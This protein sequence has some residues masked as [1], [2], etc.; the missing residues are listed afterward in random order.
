VV[1]VQLRR[2]CGKVEKW[3]VEL[4]YQDTVGVWDTIDKWRIAKKM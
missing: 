3:E 2:V 4:D 1:Q